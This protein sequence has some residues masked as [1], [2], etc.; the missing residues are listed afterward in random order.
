MKKTPNS[1]KTPFITVQIEKKKYRDFKQLYDTN[2]GQIYEGVLQIYNEL[3]ISRKRS[4]TLLVSTD[5]GPL[6]WDTEFIFKKDEYDILIDQ[7]IPYYEELEEYERC[8]EI[9]SL[10]E[11]FENK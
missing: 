9:K 11:A 1:R 2:K 5:I 8:A 7:L 4:L 6:S 10:Y 3:K